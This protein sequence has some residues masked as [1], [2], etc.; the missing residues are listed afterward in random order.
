MHTATSRLELQRWLF[1]LVLLACTLLELVGCYEPWAACC[2]HHRSY[3]PL[4]IVIEKKKHKPLNAY[5][6]LQLILNIFTVEQFINAPLVS[7]LELTK[8]TI[9]S[10]ICKRSPNCSPRVDNTQI[11]LY[12]RD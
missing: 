11:S 12:K 9:R 3:G 7:V 6:R 2:R 8:L 10:E 4:I 5:I 1:W